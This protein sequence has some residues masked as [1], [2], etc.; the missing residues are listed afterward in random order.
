MKQ[1]E[2]FWRVFNEA[3][4]DYH[5]HDNVDEPLRNP[6]DKSQIEHLLYHKNW[7]DTV[8]WQ[9]GRAHV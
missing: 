5:K 4:A 1:T 6:Y 7:V 9:I 2:L 8:Q 3:I